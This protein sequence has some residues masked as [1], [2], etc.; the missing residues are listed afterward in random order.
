MTLAFNL[1][2]VP[3]A[4][5]NVLAQ[6]R[7]GNNVEDADLITNGPNAGQLAILDGWDV[8][9]IPVTGAK[10]TQPHI[11][12]SLKGVGF[13]GFPSSMAYVAPEKSYFFVDQTDNDTLAV[14]DP[15]GNEK[16][17][18]PITYLPDS[19]VGPPQCGS[20]G[21]VYLNEDAAFPD[22]LAR[23]VFDGECLPYIQVMSREGVVQQDI[24]VHGLAADEF[25][26]TGLSYLPSG[27]FV[28]AGATGL[29]QVDL[30]GNVVDG[31]I[32]IPNAADPEGLAAS[33]SG[34]VYA[35]GYVE[36]TVTSFDKTLHLV[37]GP[38]RSIQVGVGVSRG[39]AVFW[40]PVGERWVTDGLDRDGSS[41]DVV[42]L[43]S[44]LASADL[45]WHPPGDAGIFP[46]PFLF[47]SEGPDHTISTCLEAAPFVQNFTYDGT[48]ADSLDLTTVDGLPV[49]RCRHVA[50]LPTLDAYALRLRRPDLATNIYMVSRSGTLLHTIA[51]PLSFIGSLSVDP[52]APGEVLAF[53]LEPG[54]PVLRY[55][56]ATGAL[57]ES[58]HP[59]TG[60]LRAPGVYAAGPGDTYAMLD[61]NNSEL[62]VF[63][64]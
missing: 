50:Y 52:D 29:Y 5:A 4:H 54:E 42:A 47:M 51:T 32:P 57:L 11:L 34:R 41:F 2:S 39:L 33:E 25:Y 49:R 19:P 7:L 48:P 60:D 62:A 6:A 37:T 8:V 44:D 35:T 18:R 20:E 12:F 31:P 58:F 55:D 9:G 27:R 15:Q 10:R 13:P 21:M 3:S 26:P 61:P 59:D 24:A 28:M 43:S 64:P 14:T 1:W 38:P 63:G 46:P 17:I 22:T 30:D 36:A 53:S 45:L 23:T 56:G 40:D 16:P